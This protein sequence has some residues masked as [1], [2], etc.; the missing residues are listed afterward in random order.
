[1]QISIAIPTIIY[2]DIENSF[3]HSMFLNPYYGLYIGYL[4]DRLI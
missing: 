2:E 1:M 4:L 3:L